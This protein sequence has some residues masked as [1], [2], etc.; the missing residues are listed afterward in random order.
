MNGD[1]KYKLTNH[2]VIFLLISNIFLQ[3]ISFYLSF[4]KISY[5]S[6]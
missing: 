1:I 5:I 3:N 4:V 6:I 2:L